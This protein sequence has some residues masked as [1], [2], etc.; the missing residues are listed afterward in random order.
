LGWGGGVSGGPV[1]VGSEV[2]EGSITMVLFALALALV[3][4]SRRDPAPLSADEVT[5]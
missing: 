5:L 2:T 3:M 1:A 4:A